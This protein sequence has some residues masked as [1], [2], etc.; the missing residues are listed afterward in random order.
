MPPLHDVSQMNLWY[1][2]SNGGVGF[3]MKVSFMLNKDLR[4]ILSALLSSHLPY[5]LKILYSSKV[6]PL[7]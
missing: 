5:I 3:K 2:L 7:F 1:S 6:R 4:E